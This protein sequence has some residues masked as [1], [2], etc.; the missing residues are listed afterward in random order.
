MWIG[1]NV[2]SQQA[3]FAPVALIWQIFG[4]TMEQWPGLMPDDLNLSLSADCRNALKREWEFLKRTTSKELVKGFPLNP[5]KFPLS[6]C[7]IFFFTFLFCILK[8][9]LVSLFPVISQYHFL[10]RWLGA[11]INSFISRRLFGLKKN[12]AIIP[13]FFTHSYFLRWLR[14]FTT[15]DSMHSLLFSP[16]HLNTR[17]V[18]FLSLSFFTSQSW[19]PIQLFESTLQASCW[20]LE[21]VQ[22]SLVGQAETK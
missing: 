11:S 9:N 15:A 16:S 14:L 22:V 7:M 19:M 6:C 13:E 10:P 3:I 21:S 5:F 1:Q 17:A 20:V 8:K 12:N 4:L 18:F 2:C